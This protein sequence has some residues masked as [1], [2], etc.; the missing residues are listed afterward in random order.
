MENES[1]WVRRTMVQLNELEESV[2][3]NFQ[4]LQQEF[5]APIEDR[6]KGLEGQM[7]KLPS[8]PPPDWA[9][10]LQKF[11]ARLEECERAQKRPHQTLP[12][13]NRISKKG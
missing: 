5:C 7:E 13:P 11:Q 2:N 3:K 8:L 4:G 10:V 1:E 9:P 6:I 12:P